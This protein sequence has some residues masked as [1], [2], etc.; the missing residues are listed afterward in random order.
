MS[1]LNMNYDSFKM[2]NSSITFWEGFSSYKNLTLNMEPDETTSIGRVQTTV[3]EKVD[4]QIKDGL[5]YL[6]CQNNLDNKIDSL[7]SETEDYSKR[8]DDSAKTIQE[9][10]ERKEHANKIVHFYKEEIEQ[11]TS[12]IKEDFD[13]IKRIPKEETGIISRLQQE[14]KESQARVEGLV[15]KKEVLEEQSE[16]LSREV[17]S[18]QAGIN[19]L[20]EHMNTNIQSLGDDILGF[21]IEQERFDRLLNLDLESEANLFFTKTQSPI[22]N[23]NSET[24]TDFIKSVLSGDKDALAKIQTT[25]SFNVDENLLAVLSPTLLSL[26]TKVMD[27]QV[28]ELENNIKRYLNLGNGSYSDAFYLFFQRNYDDLLHNKIKLGYVKDIAKDV[29]EGIRGFWEEEKELIKKSPNMKMKTIS[30]ITES[31]IGQAAALSLTVGVSSYALASALPVAGAVLAL[32]GAIRPLLKT[33][34]HYAFM[35]TRLAKGEIGLLGYEKEN[36]INNRFIEVKSGEQAHDFTKEFGHINI[37]TEE[38]KFQKR[39][40][41]IGLF[42]ASLK[43]NIRELIEPLKNLKEAFLKIKNIYGNISKYASQKRKQYKNSDLSK[44]NVKEHNKK[45]VN[46]VIEKMKEDGLIITNDNSKA[47]IE[48]IARYINRSNSK[49]L[50]LYKPSEIMEITQ[51]NNLVRN[52]EFKSMIDNEKISTYNLK[53]IISGVRLALGK[54]FD[55]RVDLDLV[56]KV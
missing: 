50:G 42:F 53:D 52:P 6:F 26:A 18:L 31:K 13:I 37:V 47:V 48:T 39:M 22:L 16:R 29:H 2:E 34:Q 32:Y 14:I 38:N 10:E 17:V 41:N 25:N 8:I 12:E 49:H 33:I 30:A 15:A 44:I 11:I 21:R 24:Q 27:S 19:T 43:W 7:I 51:I 55:N 9:L 1:S 45:V 4:E 20:T 28:E 3:S 35:Q 56:R 54:V 36:E 40:Y 23:F 46:E 5:N